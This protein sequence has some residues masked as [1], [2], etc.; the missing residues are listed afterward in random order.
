MK[1]MQYT[2]VHSSTME[3]DAL[4]NSSW[5][6]CGFVLWMCKLVSITWVVDKSTT[7]A[8]NNGSRVGK[9]YIGSG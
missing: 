9:I 5:R 7:S 3:S 8:W 2:H 4:T 6:G 1:T